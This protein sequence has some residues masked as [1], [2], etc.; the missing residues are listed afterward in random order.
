VLQLIAVLPFT[1][2]AV[3]SDILIATSLCVLL[4]GKKTDFEGY[5]ALRSGIV[6]LISHH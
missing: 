4:W 5:M 6:N 2:L 1:V 3:I